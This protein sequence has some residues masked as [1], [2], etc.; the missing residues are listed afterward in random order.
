MGYKISEFR[1]PKHLL[2][3]DLIPMVQKGENVSITLDHF[4]HELQDILNHIPNS[5]VVVAQEAKVRSIEATVKSEEALRA[6]KDAY[7]AS[8]EVSQD[9]TDLKSDVAANT[10]NITK[11]NVDKETLKTQIQEVNDLL[12]LAKQ[13]LDVTVLTQNTATLSKFVIKKGDVTIATIAIPVVDTSL[14]M[15]GCSADSKATGDAIQTVRDAIPTKLSAFANDVNYITEANA[16]SKYLNKT[17][18]ASIY[19]SQQNAEN[20]F[21]SKTDAAITYPSKTEVANDYLT[22]QDA[23]VTYPSKTEVA[24]QYLQKND[25]SNTYLSKSDADIKYLS[26]DTAEDTYLSKTKA[27]DVFL[28]KVD[29]DQKYLLKADASDANDAYLSKL[30]AQQTYLSQDKATQTYLTKNDAATKYYTK[31]EIDNNHYTKDETDA[32][33]DKS[34]KDYT[35]SSDTIEKDYAKKAY[36]DEVIKNKVASVYTYKGSTTYANLPSNASTGDVWNVT[37][38]HDNV[39]AGT[40]YAATVSDTG[41]VTWDALAGDIVVQNNATVLTKDVA[42]IAIINGKSIT[43]SREQ[44]PVTQAAPVALTNESKVVATIDGTDIKASIAA[45]DTLSTS[46]QNAVQNKAV[47]EKL[48]DLTT[49]LANTTEATHTLNDKYTALAADVDT[50]K[51]KIVDLDNRLT[52]QEQKEV[53]VVCANATIGNTLTTIATINNVEIK[54][55]VDALS[56]D[57]A[58]NATSENAIQNKAVTAEINALKQKNTELQNTITTLQTNLEAL[59]KSFNEITKETVTNMFTQTSGN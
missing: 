54:A 27:N 9:L 35:I 3:M 45:D 33:I 22:K 31:A 53:K 42:T 15:A 12:E 49:S 28:S 26:K 16:D 4:I 55:R 19:L 5:F 59:Q 10:K 2:P 18:A 39:P 30:E 21:L 1:E 57:A 56:V 11:L 52:T 36:V 44:I 50:N 41:V 46:S 24:S 51:H 58:L 32:L 14:T 40:N 13:Q 38:A 37:D 47:T 29:A 43:L 48:N 7:D 17:E 34:V 6:A 20:K 25:A 23:S 8:Q